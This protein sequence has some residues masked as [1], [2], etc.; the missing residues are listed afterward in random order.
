MQEAILATAILLQNFDFSF[1][2]PNYELQI[3][4]ALSI[5]PKNFYMRA[6][7][8]EKLDATAIE[9]K[10]YSNVATPEKTGKLTIDP[11]LI[12]NGKNKDPLTI[13]Y[14]SNS[15][16][17]EALAQSLATVAGSHGYEVRVNTLDSATGKVPKDQPLLIICPSYEGQPPDNASQFSAWLEGLKNKDSLSGVQFAIFGVGNRKS[18]NT[19]G[20]RGGI[21]H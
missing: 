16:T 10:L 7:L 11:N 1:D 13:L 3:Q 20:F 8:R 19:S 12:T 17:C 4:Q 9:R 14:G 21:I 5:K 6:S 15:G 2:D 18:C